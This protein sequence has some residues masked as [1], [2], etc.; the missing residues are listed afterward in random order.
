[1]KGFIAIVF[2]LFPCAISAQ[3]MDTTIFRDAA[4]H[5]RAL[6]YYLK[7][8][9]TGHSDFHPYYQ[10][11]CYASLLK[12]YDRAFVYLKEAIQKGARGEDVMTDTDFDVL[13]QDLTQWNEI[14]S[15]LKEQYFQRY[16]GISKLDAGYELWLMWIEDQRYRTLKKNYKLDGAP[17]TDIAQHNRH[18][19]RLK[20][21]IK[22]SGW[23]KYSEVGIEGGDAVFFIFQHDHAGQMK[24]VLPLFIAAAKAGEAD[25][26][27]AAMMIDRYLAYSE[28]VQIYGTQ[29]FRKV[30]QGQNRNDIPLQ[31]YPIADEANLMARREAI[32]MPGFFENCQRLGVAYIP[33]SLRSNYKAIPIKKKW[34]KAGFLL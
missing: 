34:R 18:L 8:I 32:G 22:D 5:T 16:P 30:E 27:K 33:I 28:K 11:A 21:I 10:A 9:E 31:L 13:K 24:E 15:L 20:E 6:E 1:M 14:D 4:N 7:Q 17:T 26:K 3:E 12:N 2:Y 29:A 23:P 25:V 19:L